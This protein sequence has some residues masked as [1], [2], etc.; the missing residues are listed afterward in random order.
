MHDRQL[1]N[2]VMALKDEIISLRREFHSFPEL[3]FREFKTSERIASYLRE[4]GYEVKTG[5]AG[6]GVSALLKGNAQSPV[7]LLRGDIDA[8]P[9]EEE[10]ELASRRS[11]SYDACM[12]KSIDET[13]ESYPRQHK[14][15]FPTQ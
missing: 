14:I 2:E 8:L 5:I 9:I 1:Y 6:T 4:L 7:L 12:C 13:Q 11:Y 10:T 15:L 3:G